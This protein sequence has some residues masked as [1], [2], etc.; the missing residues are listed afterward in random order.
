MIKK[1]KREECKGLLQTLSKTLPTLFGT[2]LKVYLTL[3]IC[4]HWISQIF[5][6][7]ILFFLW[8]T[9]I[10]ATLN[11]AP[12]SLLRSKCQLIHE[13][14]F[15]P[16]QAPCLF[17]YSTSVCIRTDVLKRITSQSMPVTTWGFSQDTSGL[18]S[19]QDLIGSKELQQSH[20]GLD[21]KRRKIL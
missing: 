19:L 9:D 5:K 2:F 18:K 14:H 8:H 20:K 21:W 12:T 13:Q 4:N 17:C 1:N 3:R 10:T 15:S 7:N 16:K 11:I 6:C